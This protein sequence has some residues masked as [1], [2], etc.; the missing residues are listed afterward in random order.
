MKNTMRVILVVG[1]MLLLSACAGLPEKV[2]GDA[3]AS[4]R[5]AL[6]HQDKSVRLYARPDFDPLRVGAF[7][8]DR[9]EVQTTSSLDAEQKAEQELLGTDLAT[10]ISRQLTTQNSASP[11]HMDILLHDIKPTSPALNILTLVLVLAPLDT[12]AMIVET[13]YRDNAGQI[14]ARRIEQLTGSIFNIRASLSAYGQHKLML[15]E[16]AQRCPM[17]ASCLIAR[18]EQ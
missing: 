16:W 13:T 5:L 6:I 17:M 8:L 12:G 3:E 15:S 4:A 9:V 14:Q 1:C 11:L 18:S 10:Q 7:A 2:H